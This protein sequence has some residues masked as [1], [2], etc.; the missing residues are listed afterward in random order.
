MGEGMERIVGIHSEFFR[1]NKER[2]GG[3]DADVAGAVSHGSGP[4]GRGCIVPRAA[5]DLHRP[6]EAQGLCHLRLQRPGDLVA[7]KK[8]W[9]LP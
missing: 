1:G 4:Y 8:L 5:D 9:Q 6:S 2:S 7:L 3:A